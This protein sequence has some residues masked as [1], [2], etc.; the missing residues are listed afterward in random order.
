M[1]FAGRSHTNRWCID[2]VAVVRHVRTGEV[3]HDKRA[4]QAQFACHHGARDDACQLLSVQAKMCGMS[5]FD[6]EKAQ[7]S[8]L[9]RQRPNTML[10]PTVPTSIEGTVT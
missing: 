2:N 7:Y 9:G 6:T 5:A 3:A 8:A 1:A 4:H 10:A